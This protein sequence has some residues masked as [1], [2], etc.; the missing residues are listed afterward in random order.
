MLRFPRFSLTFSC[1]LFAVAHL[2]AQSCS[3]TSNTT[4]CTAANG[5]ISVGGGSAESSPYPLPLAVSGTGS[6]T[7]QKITVTLNKLTSTSGFSG[8]DFM[9]VLVSPHNEQLELLSQYC[10]DATD[11]SNITLTFDDTVST[12]VNN[13]AGA[14]AC[15]GVTSGTFHTSALNGFGTGLDNVPGITLSS[16]TVAQTYGTGTFA[17]Q[18]T[19]DPSGTWK[20]YVAMQTGNY[21]TGTLGGASTPPWS[22]SIT[23][24]ASAV[25]TTTAIARSS[26]SNPAFS[27]DS[28]TFTATVT[29]SPSVGTVTFEDNGNT[30]SGCSGRTISG[31][32]ATCSASL[33]EGAHDVTAVYSG[34]T[35]FGPSTSPAL[36]QVTNN[37]TSVNGTSFC[38]TGAITLPSSGD[39]AQPVPASPYASEVFVSGLP[40]IVQQVTVSLKGINS[41]ALMEE[42]FMLVGPNGKALDFLSYA[43]G[44]TAISGV[45]LTIADGSGSISQDS[46][47]AS[48]TYEPTSNVSLGTTYCTQSSLTANNTCNN[49][50]VS[51]AAPNT[52][53]SATNLGTGTLE[54]QFGGSTPNGTW[55]LFA[56]NR[57]GT[58]GQQTQLT[59]G[60][61]VNLTTTTGDATSTSVASGQNPS[62]TAT[63]N[64]SVL[65]TATISDTPNPATAVNGGTVLFTSDGATISGCGSAAVTNGLATCTTTALPEGVHSIV[66]EY[67][68][69]A[70]F[71]P[72]NGSLT[73]TVY[74]HPTVTVNGA[75]YSYCNSGGV[76]IPKGEPN[77]ALRG[78]SQPFPSNMVVSGLPGTLSSMT[79]GL[80]TFSFTRPD[81]LQS[82]L[83]GPAGTAAQSLDFLSQLG[84]INP[85]SNVSFTMSDAGSTLSGDP[86]NGGTFHPYS[87]GTNT[88]SSPA[89]A[90]PYNYAAPHGS[91]TFSSVFGSGPGNTLNANGIWSLYFES[92]TEGGYGSVASWCLNLTENLPDI[93]LQ[94]SAM[95]HSPATFKRGQSGSFTITVTNNGPGPSGGT[96]TVTDTLPS[97]LTFT[98]GT[99]TDWSCSAVGQAVTCTNSDQIALNAS[100]AVTINFS[101]GNTTADSITNSASLTGI[102]SNPNNN[103]ATS[104]TV[105]V[106][107]TNLTINKTHTDPFAP[108]QTGATYTITVHNSGAANNNS[109]PGATMGTVT[110]TDMLP[111]IFT[112]TAISGG[113]AWTCQT[114]PALM[115]TLNGSLAVGADSQITLT[116]NVSPSAG[117]TVTNTAVL[118]AAA[119]QLGTNPVS[120]DNATNIVGPPVITSPTSGTV[121][122]NTTVTVS[123]TSLANAS[124]T[125][126]DGGTQVGSTTADGSGNFT[127]SISLAIGVHSLTAKQTFNAVTSGAS[128][129]VSVTVAPPA[130]A[131]TS[132]TSGFSTTNTTVAVSGTSL[133]NA[134]ISIRD[135]AS[136]VGST[137][138]NGTGNWATNVSLAIGTH[139]LTA[140]QT[141]N[142]VTSAASSAVSV[143][144][145]PPAPVITSPTSGFSTTNTTVAVSGTSLPNA[146]VSITDGIS[147]VGSTTAD[148]SGNWSTNVTLAIGTHSLTATQTVNGA[149]SA[150]SNTVAVTVAPPPPAITSP[151]SGFSTTNP[152]VPV[153]GTSVANASISILD[154]AS[155]VGSTTANGSGSW[156]VNVTL[157]IGGHSLTATQTVSGLTSLAS[158]TV[159]VT[160]LKITP[161]I[162]WANPADIT[163]GGALSSVQL[164]ATASVPGTFVYTPPAGTVLP[165][166]D[167]QTL[168]VAFTPTDTAH[169]NNASANVTINV[170]PAASGPANLVITRSLARDGSNNLVVTLT[171]ANTGGTA[172][173]NVVLTTVNIGAAVPTTPLPLSVGTIAAGGSQSVSVQF[174]AASVPGSGSTVVISYAGTFTGNT[175]GGSS[176]ATLP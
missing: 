77:N 155:L 81:W 172:A 54:N 166:G 46:P 24:N 138:A 148:G 75:T 66:A 93:S 20:L 109:G 110:V 34:G 159:S 121:T 40:G 4:T 35:G 23:M 6:G 85:F 149:K 42:G 47:V 21:D 141:V 8:G 150:A 41:P 82:L 170:K 57:G 126:F 96:L 98:S 37:P 174:A 102:D 72:S 108:G 163:F 140:T 104:G 131:I 59:G 73:Q 18:F 158:N 45:N 39:V 146:A 31:G 152:V 63:P 143:T 32:Q 15:S 44:S 119:D 12:Y 78:P 94:G 161:T 107:G 151:T 70:S 129:A 145:G 79:V 169:Y 36:Y 100:S 99:G 1:L 103:T 135:G 101:V 65:L 153:S 133:P 55:Q 5:T 28:L 68:G 9:V 95:T 61:C 19:Q 83:V 147:L 52:F 48:G 3:T 105:P 106:E 7:I 168:S 134:S 122:T 69:T 124:I 92:T 62:Y 111:D 50:L 89:P 127:T 88:Y 156:T 97:G 112:A 60:W 17:N 132:P 33:A 142:A 154:G 125:I 176:R 84:T 118:N 49:V 25:T 162:T 11:I 22:I 137:T 56:V 30:I 139:S 10:N 64:N 165:V 91:A 114:L 116:V 113:A 90:G 43:G 26:G 86:I 51:E 2:N 16:S 53:V 175:F 87:G 157:G 171:I 167:G 80:N 160:I 117:G 71:G 144:V 74:V 38:N 136:M 128:G 67:S 76:A 58:A 27:T 14:N 130:P 123:G 115:C 29:P 13:G 164:N 120:H 173:T